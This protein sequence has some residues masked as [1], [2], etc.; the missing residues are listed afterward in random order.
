MQNHSQL[1]TTTTTTTTPANIPTPYVLLATSLFTIVL[2]FCC[3][4]ISSIPPPHSLL[5]P[6]L[7]PSDN[8][9]R[10]LFLEPSSSPS[11]WSDKARSVPSPP[12]IAYFI[13]G[14]FND[15]NRIFRLL[16]ATY[17]PKNFYLLHLDSN[18]PQSE[19]DALARTVQSVRL[20]KAAQNVYVVGKADVVYQ[21]GS[22]SLSST[23][24]GAS[25]L[26]RVF[27]NW[28]WFINLSVD[29]YPLV[30]QDGKS[31]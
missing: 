24:H 29:D 2:V 19:R 18:A 30:T 25:I 17:H 16:W 6:A 11:S 23:L 5:H 21:K 22:S 14:S 4:S 7:F 10:V 27:R 8:L 26:L 20:F 13:S 3:F 28:D 12:S 31:F 9:H 1:S 15:T